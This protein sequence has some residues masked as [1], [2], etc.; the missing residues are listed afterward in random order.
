MI[1]FNGYISGSAEKRF[2]QKSRGVVQAAF[3][4]ALLLFLPVAIYFGIQYQSWL[5]IVGYCAMFAVVFLA[6]R[7]PK[8]KKE[9]LAMLPKR[10]YVEGDCI[11]CVANQY[12]ETKFL[13][14]VKQVIDH[15]EFYELTFPFGNAS[16]K[17]ICQKSLLSK[18]SIEKFE[19]LFPGKI[20]RKQ[21][22]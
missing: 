18:G 3:M 14:D 8:S 6:L 4:F 16:E 15:G 19:Q 22:K 17:F 20:V 10:I 7:I 21:G 13:D 2:Y 12:R 11:V 1:E 9:K 5:I